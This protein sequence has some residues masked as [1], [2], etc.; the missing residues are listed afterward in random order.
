MRAECL[1]DALGERLF[2]VEGYGPGSTGPERRAALRQVAYE[3]TGGGAAIRW[4]SKRGNVV[5]SSDLDATPE[6]DGS[7]RVGRADG[8]GTRGRLRGEARGVAGGA[9]AAGGPRRVPRG[10]GR[11]TPTGGDDILE[12]GY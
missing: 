10:R 9:A 4:R 6:R 7:R 12:S 11:P 1:R 8:A 3:I 2:T 5:V